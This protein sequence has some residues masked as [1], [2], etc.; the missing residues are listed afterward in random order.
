[1][2]ENKKEKAEQCANSQKRKK[3][4]R[5]QRLRHGGTTQKGKPIFSARIPAPGSTAARC[6]TPTICKS[7]KPGCFAGLL[8]RMLFYIAFNLRCLF[9][10]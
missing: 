4:K 1:M 10:Q 6:R 9:A 8:P 3:T 5:A 2:K 7:E